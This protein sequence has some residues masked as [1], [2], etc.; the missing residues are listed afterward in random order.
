MVDRLLPQHRLGHLERVAVEPLTVAVAPA[1]VGETGELRPADASRLQQLEVGLGYR[2]VAEIE[3]DHQRGVLRLGHRHI[4]DRALQVECQG[5]LD[6]QGD[7]ALAGR[8]DVRISSGGWGRQHQ[9]LHVLFASE[10]LVQRG[11]GRPLAEALPG[12]LEGVCVRVDVG[13]QLAIRR[14]AYRLCPVLA[15]GSQTHQDHP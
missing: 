7:L 15:S 8:A 4:A 14:S 6:Q 11:V 12:S 1:L 10:R 13:E 5:F 9:R 2:Q 3:P